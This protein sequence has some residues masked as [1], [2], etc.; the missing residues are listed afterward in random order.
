MER[1]NL[2]RQLAVND[3]DIMLTPRGYTEKIL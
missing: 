2:K 3:P 1:E